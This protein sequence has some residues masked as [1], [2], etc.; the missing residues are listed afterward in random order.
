MAN[1]EIEALIGRVAMRDQKAFAVLYKR[2]SSK[3]LGVSLRIVG[4]KADAEEILQEVYVR[5]WQ[6]AEQFAASEGPAIPWLTAIARK[7]AIDFVRP[8]ARS[9]RNR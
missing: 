8:Q 7:R 9:R 6:R 5:I 4:N 1:E 2:T 3:L